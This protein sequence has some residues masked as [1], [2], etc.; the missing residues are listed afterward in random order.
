MR[1]RFNMSMSGRIVILSGAV[2][3][4]KTTICRQAADRAEQHGLDCAGILCPARFVGPDKVGIDLLDLRTKQ[5]RSLAEA[6]DQPAALRTGKY[7]F[8]VE[9]MT[10]GM[11]CLET[12]CPCDL[13]IIDELGPL[14][15]ERGEGWVNA[16]DILRAG[17]FEMALVVVRPGLV[18][19]FGTL[20]GP[21]ELTIFTLPYGQSDRDLPGDLLALLHR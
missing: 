18:K 19:P 17:Q 13:L 5:R 14:E 3:S 15:L 7:R 1:E 12:A 16:L 9:A 8:D 10:W 2:G 6:D 4:G 11:A 20:M 21:I